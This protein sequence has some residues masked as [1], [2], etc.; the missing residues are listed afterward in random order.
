MKKIPWWLSVLIAIDQLL[1]AMLWGW[2]D[3]TLSSRAYRMAELEDN[4]KTRWII[5]RYL[6]DK[7][8]F[9]QEDHCYQSFLT[10]RALH[11]MPIEVR[12]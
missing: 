10:E 4:P 8:F 6:I 3:E 7:M 9:W 2:P 12:K 11:Q 1:N 5:A